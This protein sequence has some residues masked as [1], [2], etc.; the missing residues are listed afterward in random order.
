MKKILVAFNILVAPFI[1]CRCQLF[2]R[3]ISD[4]VWEQ[5][6][7][8][9]YSFSDSSVPPEF[10]RS[11]SLIVTPDSA[12]ISIYS[13]G[14]VLLKDTYDVSPEKFSKAVSELRSLGIRKV[15]R[16]HASPCSGG[17]SETLRLY[18]GSKVLFDG[19]EDNCQERMSTMRVGGRDIPEA[20]GDV[21]P[22]PVSEIVDGTRL[23]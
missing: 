1:L 19:Y 11:F 4:S 21:F 3:S 20:L 16:G 18:A 17:T 2:D 15:R 7:R 22:K 5:T 14:D 10:H 8:I 13:Y 12:A 9:E 23:H 6:D